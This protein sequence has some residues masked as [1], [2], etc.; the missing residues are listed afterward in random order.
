MKLRFPGNKNVDLSFTKVMGTIALSVD[1]KRSPA[2]ILSEAED[3]IKAGAEFIEIGLSRE[4]SERRDE[5]YVITVL[6]YLLNQLE[7]PV[8]VCTENK[9]VLI[10]AIKLGVAMVITCNGIKS[11]QVL[12]ALKSSKTIVCLH[13]EAKEPLDDEADLVSYLS[14]FFYTNIDMLLNKGIARKRIIIDP[15][16]INASAKSRMHLLGR[17]ESFKSFAL[18]MCIGMPRL[19]PYA[20][21]FLSENKTLSLTASLFCSQ[22]GDVKIIRTADVSDV[23]MA[24]GF[25]QLMTIKTRPYR[26]SKVF[27]RRLRTLRDALRMMRKGFIKK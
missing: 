8:A 12:T 17:L 25:W 18:P 20:D 24:I 9:A 6:E 13:A 22:V 11:M 15:S 1:E 19:I 7:V 2:E 10:N 14:E 23:S 21:H 5:S 26:L 4:G 3:F 27:V 16:L